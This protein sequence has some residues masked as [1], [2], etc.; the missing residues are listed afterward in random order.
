MKGVKDP[1]ESI[2]GDPIRVKLLRIF[3]SD[4]DTIYSV[5]EFAG[6]LRRKDSLI[7]TILRNM[8][9]DGLIM[10]KKL[11]PAKRKRDN[12]RETHGYGFN[13]RYTH[14]DFLEKIIKDSMPNERDMLAKKLARVPGV[15]CVVT[16]DIFLNDSSGNM[17]VLVASRDNNEAFLK[18]II[19]ETEKLIGRELHC[20]FLTV[21]DFMYRIQTKDKFIHDIL[22]G[23][24]RVHV[25][26]AGIFRGQ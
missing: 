7:Q 19:Q 6:A 16:T 11:S 12:L 21:N 26:R 13:K 4:K 1:L 14:K 3:V 22:A 2:I 5:K 17:D 8:E 23:E 18:N 15:Q 9:K 20:A 24:H 25:D 10:K